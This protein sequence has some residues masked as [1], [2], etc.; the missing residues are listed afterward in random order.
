LPLRPKN[1]SIFRELHNLPLHSILVQSGAMQVFVAEASSIPCSLNEIGRLR[2]ISFRAAGEGTGKDLDL[3]TFDQTYLHLVLFSHEK[4]EI[5]GAYRMG[6]TDLLL[7][8]YG[9]RGL[10]TST[11]F[12]YTKDFIERIGPALELGRSFI[13]PEYQRSPS[14]LFLLWKGIG[15]FISLH[16]QYRTL[17]G[18]VSISDSY[19]ACSKH[20][21][22]RFLELNCSF[23][24]LSDMVRPRRPFKTS[25]FR[26]LDREI[27]RFSSNDLEEISTWISEM[28]ND[29]KGLPILLK[30]Y[31]KLGGKILSLSVDPSFGN[32]IDGLIVVDLSSADSRVLERYMGSSSFNIYRQSQREG[33]QSLKMAA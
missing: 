18:P 11:L 31:I 16:P 3:D 19:L 7:P 24:P 30:H 10:Y 27:S 15:Q 33:N 1:E 6:P 29:R 28:E 23:H 32:V 22:A 17:F 14:A 20:L 2:E 21:I 26:Y 9:V 13:R 4:K 25:G 5:V 12:R 8:R